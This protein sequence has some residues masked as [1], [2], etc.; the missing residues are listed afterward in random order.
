MQLLASEVNAE[1]YT[2]HPGIVSLL[3]LTITY[4]QALHRHVYTG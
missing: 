2:N 4:T 3:M 1:Y